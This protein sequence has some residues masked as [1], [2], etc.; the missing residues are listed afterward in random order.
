MKA[1]FSDRFC[2]WWFSMRCLANDYYSLWRFT[3]FAPMK[4]LRVAELQLEV[5][6]AAN[7]VSLIF[8]V[9]VPYQLAICAKSYVS[10]SNLTSKFWKSDFG[11]VLQSNK[12]VVIIIDRTF[13]VHTSYSVANSPVGWS[14][15][16]N[17]GSNC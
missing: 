12:A 7:T 15:R 16:C 17:D 10:S 8:F 4:H 14:L 9:C 5:H 3:S 2:L 11:L 6:N 13:A 1:H